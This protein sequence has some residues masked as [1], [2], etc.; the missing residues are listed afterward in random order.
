MPLIGVFFLAQ[1][2]GRALLQQSS[3]DWA[4]QPVAMVVEG[5]HQH[6]GGRGKSATSFIGL[7]QQ[8][9]LGANEIVSASAEGW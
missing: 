1:D 4:R 2:K 9:Q 6:G 3:F 7:L 5:S 8:G